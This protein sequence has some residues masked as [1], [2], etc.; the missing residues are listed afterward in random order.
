MASAVRVVMVLAAAGVCSAGAG[1]QA[2]LSSSTQDLINGLNKKR[3][4]TLSNRPFYR[5]LWDESL[6]SAAG[7]VLDATLAC[8]VSTAAYSSLLFGGYSSAALLMTTTPNA[9]GADV[10]WDAAWA[11]DL[12]HLSEIDLTAIGCAIDNTCGLTLCFMTKDILSLLSILKA[13][14]MLGT[15]Q[16]GMV[17]IE[18][19]VLARHD[20][21]VPY[22]CNNPP[23]TFSPP[24]S[25]PTT[26]VPHTHTPSVPDPTV[27]PPTTPPTDTN[28]P[29]P[30]T[31]TTTAPPTQPPTL[32]PTVEPTD[33][34][35]GVTNPPPPTTEIPSTEAPITDVPVK[36]TVSPKVPPP[37]T[38]APVK[39]TEEPSKEPSEA[40]LSATVVPPGKDNTTANNAT[41]PLPFWVTPPPPTPIKEE[42]VPTSMALALSGAGVVC[43]VVWGFVGYFL[44]TKGG[45]ATAGAASLAAGGLY[46]T[47]MSPMGSPTA[48]SAGPSTGPS[49]GIP[50]T[51]QLLKE[52]SNPYTTEVYSL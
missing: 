1:C 50:L 25:P 16:P 28:T 10:F 43:L 11:T 2:D 6:A 3:M 8:K 13:T 5:V 7:I 51:E 48:S 34:P 52:L 36:R 41:L 12:D 35:V 46:H 24:T 44:F 20:S 31:A 47:A 27:A 17:D 49:K 32:P 18:D 15:V 37:P 22:F 23:R 19:S 42:K 29:I 4:A 40:P 45:A 26:S 39:P 9:K 38:E 30:I 14:G 33:K 21:L